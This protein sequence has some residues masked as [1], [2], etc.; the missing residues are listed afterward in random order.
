VK[1]KDHGGRRPSGPD[2]GRNTTLHTKNHL[3]TSGMAHF[4]TNL[5]MFRVLSEIEFLDYT[6]KLLAPCNASS[7]FAEV[8]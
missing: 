3:V 5:T 7:A 1:S 8:K 6:R 4:E 2:R